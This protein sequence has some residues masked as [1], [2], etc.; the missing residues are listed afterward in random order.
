MSSKTSNG[1]KEGKALAKTYLVEVMPLAKSNRHSPAGE[2]SYFS[3]LK[4]APGTI[5]KVPMRNGRVNAVVLNSRSAASAKS[6]L[7]KAAFALKKIAKKDVFDAAITDEF[8]SAVKETASYYATSPGTLLKTLLPKMIL[9]EPELFF[10]NAGKRRKSGSGMAKEP[11]LLQ[12]E[13]DERFGQYRAMVRQCF[14]RRASVMFVVPTHLDALKAQKHLSQGIAEY[15]HVFTLKESAEEAGNIWRKARDEKHPVLFITTPAGLAFDRRDLGTIVIEREN[16]RAWRTLNY[17]YIHFQVFIEKLSKATLRQLVLGDSVLSIETL[18]NWKEKSSDH[19]ELSL[20][21]WRLPAAPTTLVDASAKPD[22]NGKFEIFSPELKKLIAKALEEKERIFLF[23]ARKGLYPTTICGDCGFI[24]PCLNCGA[25]VVLHGAKAGNVYICHACGTRRDSATTCGYCGSWKLVALGIGIERIAAEARE[26]F[27]GTSISILDKDHAPN[28]AKAQSI[29]HKFTTQG[30]ILV[31][32]ELALF[33]LE[34]VP[35]ASLV[36]ADSLFS[37]PDFSVNEKIFYLV[38]R[39][40]E[41]S[42]KETVIQTRNIGKQ[43]LA[44]AAQGNIIDFYGNEVAERRELLY[45]PFSVFI[46]ITSL[47]ERAPQDILIIK[48]RFSKWHPDSFKD[49]LILRMPKEQWPDQELSDAL[50]LLGREFSIKVDP[51]SII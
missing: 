4:I 19:G 44:W 49:S 12:M 42:E 45:P 8:L 43:I 32:T 10:Q 33:Y 36:S 21:R 51:E 15:V 3:S 7:R 27:P 41:I 28:D 22:Q 31:G 39:L 38:S 17:P 2:L 16:S 18:W 40:R 47:S 50:S 26:L 5:V 1:V 25:P 20:V 13:S 29:A 23:G 37:I 46:K 34:K 35:Y 48:E 11:L 6:E 24:L 9:E 14:A 30:G